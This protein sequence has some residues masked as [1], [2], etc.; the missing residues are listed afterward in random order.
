MDTGLDTVMCGTAFLKNPGL[1][2]KFADDLGVDV[3]MP[4]QIQWAFHGRGKK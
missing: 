4:N 2:F 3:R 1:V